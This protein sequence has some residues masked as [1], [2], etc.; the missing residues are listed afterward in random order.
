[1]VRAIFTRLTLAFPTINEMGL[2]GGDMW[3]Q[4]DEAP[5]R[6][7]RDVRMVFFHKNGRVGENHWNGHLAAR[8]FLPSG[9]SVWGILRESVFSERI[10]ELEQ[11]RERITN[12]FT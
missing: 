1:M 5:P 11:L 12:S 7:A 6:F 10:E 9:L 3:C 8:N 4:Q 2:L